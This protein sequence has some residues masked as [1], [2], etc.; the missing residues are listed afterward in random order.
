MMLTFSG[1]LDKILDGSKTMT[2]RLDAKEMK[3]RE[4]VRKF[5]AGEIVVGHM[6][7]KN[8]RTG[9][10]ECYKIGQAQIRQVGRKKGEYLDTAD[11]IRDGFDDLIDYKDALADLNDMG[12][13]EVDRTTWTQ[14]RWN[15]DF[16]LDGPHPRKVA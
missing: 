6:W 14:I 8:P 12:W 15:K 10:P 1:Q 13:T 4:A 5:N 9:H 11:A 7:W 3:Y 16:W 2:T